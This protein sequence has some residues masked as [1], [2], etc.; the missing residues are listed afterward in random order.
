[1]NALRALSIFLVIT[2]LA[3]SGCGD[4]GGPSRSSQTAIRSNQ[5]S[6]TYGRFTVQAT[7]GGGQQIIGGQFMPPAVMPVASS[8]RHVILVNYTTKE[9]MYYRGGQA[10]L[11]FAVVTPD[12]TYLPRAVVRGRVSGIE[13]YPTW[14][15][16]PHIRSAMPQLPAGCL[17]YDHPQNVLGIAKFLINWDVGGWD[18]VRLHGSGGYPAGS[19]WQAETFGCI[20]LLDPAMQ[21]LLSA[22]G[23][24]GVRE[25]IE[26]VV[27]R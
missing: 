4:T 7:A 9:L 27:Y 14:C 13:M 19:F 15:P 26:I 16:T 20:N 5:P 21:Q 11:G 1:M 8:A 10:T 17:S 12:V 18:T 24:A 3:L 22:I 6:Y 2:T 25:G 23:S